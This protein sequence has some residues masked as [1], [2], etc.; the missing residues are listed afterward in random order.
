MKKVILLILSIITSSFLTAQEDSTGRP[1]YIHGGTYLK[2]GAVIP[3]G[4]YANGQTIPFDYPPVDQ[5]S[6]LPARSGAALDLG[7]IIYIGP[8]FANKYLRAGIDATFFSFWFNSTRPPDRTYLYEKYY[9]FIGQKFGPILTVNP[10][11]RLMI[12]FSYKL[13]ANF[14]Y[15]DELD[16]W[17]PLADVTTSEYGYSLTGNE[18][19][20]NIRYRVMLFSF[21]YNFGTM[22]YNNADKENYDQEIK[23]NTFRILLGFKF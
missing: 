5:L 12:D 18:V 15:H 3:V 14:A 7:F 23:I 1:D 21:Q 10:V 2:I 9:S 19:S 13:N 16:G 8:S 6:Y 22:N 4:D 17:A 11:D 20:M